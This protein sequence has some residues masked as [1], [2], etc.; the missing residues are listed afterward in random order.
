MGIVKVHKKTGSLLDSLHYCLC[1]YKMS[2]I[3]LHDYTYLKVGLMW[4]IEKALLLKKKF[5]YCNYPFHSLQLQAVF[6][7]VQHGLQ[8]FMPVDANTL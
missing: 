7:A 6:V 5:T 2:L 8:V 1:A 4:I 3:S